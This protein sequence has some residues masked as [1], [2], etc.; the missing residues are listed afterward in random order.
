LDDS[1]SDAQLR[2]DELERRVAANQEL[3]QNLES[4][5][6]RTFTQEENNT[7]SDRDEHSLHRGNGVI[8]RTP[9][10]LRWTLETRETKFQDE[11]GK[12]PRLTRFQS[13]Q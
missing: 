1:S 5:D 2:Q 6:F 4:D 12:M 11:L 9:N 10:R 13:M 3:H 7:A 8:E